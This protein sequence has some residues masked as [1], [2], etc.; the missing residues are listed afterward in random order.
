MALTS[1]PPNTFPL[2]LDVLQPA[3]STLRAARQRVAVFLS[4]CT[5]A[6]R[7]PPPPAKQQ[8]RRK[9]ASSGG[10]GDDDDRNDGDDNDGNDNDDKDDDGDDDEDD[11]DDDTKNTDNNNN[12]NN[13]GGGQDGE[14]TAGPDVPA[15]VLLQ[16]Q[17][18]A[19]NL[20]WECSAAV[21]TLPVL[22]RPGESAEDLGDD[23]VDQ[24][25]EEVVGEEEEEEEEEQ[26][27]E[28]EGTTTDA[29]AEHAA[30]QE[31]QDVGSKGKADK[32]AKKR[33]KPAKASHITFDD[34]EDMVDAADAGAGAGADAGTNNADEVAGEG[35]AGPEEAQE[36]PV[37]AKKKKNGE[38]K[39]SIGKAT[40]KSDGAEESLSKK[41]K[42]DR[43]DDAHGGATAVKE[44]SQELPSTPVKVL[45]KKAAA[46]AEPAS[47]ERPLKKVKK[48]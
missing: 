40:P 44:E 31:E 16:L 5:A 24:E 34:D 14:A 28:A 17:S 11:D 4:A 9:H 18:L 1:L 8:R 29:A 10:D 25:E 12:N 32:P 27:A 13:G 43:D 33:T 21:E 45:K 15:H 46:K 6:P 41:R 22:V 35:A 48:Q 42:A 3:R 23:I 20:E 37:K 26:A 36:T 30:D 38:G 7:A 19:T 47:E 2:H 39:K